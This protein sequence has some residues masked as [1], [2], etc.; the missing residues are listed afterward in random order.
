MKGLSDLSS[1]KERIDY[2]INMSLNHRLQLENDKE[3]IDIK[4]L[5]IEKAINIL[6]KANDET[7]S[8][9]KK[10]KRKGSNP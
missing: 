1:E 5:E 8:E 2:S 4:I 6:K 10:V 3:L 9:N 7:T